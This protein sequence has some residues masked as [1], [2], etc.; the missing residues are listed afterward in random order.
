MGF[1]NFPNGVASYGVPV[2]NA[3]MARYGI[4]GPVKFLASWGQQGTGG[5]DT[6]YVTLAAALADPDFTANRGGAVIALPG[7]SENI[8][9]ATALDSLVDGVAIIGIG[10]GTAKPTFRM[11]ATGSQ[12]VLDNNNTILA[13]CKLRLEGAVVVKALNVTGTDFWLDACDVEV[14]SGASNKST[15]A[16]EIGSGAVRATVSNN[17]FRGT[18][19][20]NVTDGI[21]VVGAT[22]PSD[23]TIVDNDM[24]FSATAGNGLIHVTVAVKRLLIKNTVMYNTHTASTATVAL[25]DV[26][27]DGLVYYGG[28][29][30][31]NDGTV[32]AQGVVFA[33]SSVL[34][35]CI[36]HLA[37]D[38]KAKN[39]ILSPGVCT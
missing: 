4:M 9:V 21:K 26:A 5:Y 14:A 25:D 24:I 18:E 22:V 27:A 11:T 38:E 30:N 23:L 1:T 31:V 6:P 32:T 36:Q 34:V 12:F 8:A 19:T 20:H 13:G 39:A 17:R 16:M 35:K 29:A 7:H 33:G 3:A 10:Q 2:I 28:S 15:I 37:V